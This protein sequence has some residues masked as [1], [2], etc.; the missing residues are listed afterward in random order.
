MSAKTVEVLRPF[1]LG[2][3]ATEVGEVVTLPV[4]LADLMVNGG[5]ARVVTRDP[6]P[7]H[8]DPVI[9]AGDTPPV[10]D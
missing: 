8:R 10:D 1:H 5:K 4:G 2:A 6:A 9:A 7:V 3:R